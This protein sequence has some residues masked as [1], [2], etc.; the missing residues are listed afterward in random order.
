MF[1]SSYVWNRVT[2]TE[3]FLIHFGYSGDI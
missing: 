3:L 1:H 2:W